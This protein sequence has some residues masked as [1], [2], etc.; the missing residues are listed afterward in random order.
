VHY[1][2]NIEKRKKYLRLITTWSG[3]GGSEIEWDQ[4]GAQHDWDVGG[5]GA[6]TYDEIVIEDAAHG[7]VYLRAGADQYIEEMCKHFPTP[8][9]RAAIVKWVKLNQDV[10]QKG[11]FFDLKVSKPAWLARLMAGVAGRKFFES[12]R[13][14]ALTVAQELTPDKGLQAALLG[15]FGDYGRVPSEESF[16]IHASVA[17]HYFNGGFYPRGGSTV[18][19]NKIVPVIERAG[20]RVLVRK[21]V[22][23]ILM[24]E[25]GAAC[26]VRMDGGDEIF[27][28]QIIS[29]CGVFNTY[30]N[31]LPPAVVEQRCPGIVDKITRIGNS[32]S[33][34]YLFVGME[35]TPEELQV[36]T[37]RILLLEFSFTYLSTCLP[38]S[39][40]RATS[41]RGRRETTI[42]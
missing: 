33:M 39:C 19:A 1:I 9:H 11:V 13:K 28:P 37:T 41:G 20:G 18:I 5:K 6:K 12:T 35:G 23:S 24:D 10:S 2:G 36:S 14:S 29:G 21:A 31:L 3:G 34:C 30:K 40:A 26:G 27:A 16:F 8:E 38:T 32:C 4:M 25:H 42:R 22:E 15:Q 17:N 7:P